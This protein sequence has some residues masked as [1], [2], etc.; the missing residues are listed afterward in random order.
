MRTRELKRMRAMVKRLNGRQRKILAA[1]L[2]AI[3]LVPAATE[4]A[5]RRVEGGAA[6]PHCAGSHIV[7]NGSSGGMQRYLCRTCR[8]TFNGLTGT[9]LARLRMKGK[10][11]GQAEALRD[12]LSL[13]QVEERLSIARTTAFRWRHRF[14]VLP[15][16]LRAELLTGVAE[17]DETYFL[18]SS[19]G[20][21]SGLDRKPRRRGG[22]ASRPGVS[23]E[24][25]P[26]L[27]ARDRAGGTADFILKSDD[28]DHIVEKLKPILPKD[29]ILCTEG[30][31]VMMATGRKLAV[32][33][34]AVNV[35]AGIRVDGPWHV[36]NVN[37]YHSRL[38]T[39]LRR[40]KGVATRYLDSYLGWFRAIDRSPAVISKPASF[41]AMAVGM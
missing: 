16:D 12:G 8:K 6:C 3:E 1:D 27:V 13:T 19:K 38:K 26:V 28:S 2:A 10:W 9:P 23:S 32:E 25:V 4:V 15:K 11:L 7:K 37:S 33:H 35:A 5:E 36:Q 41:L 31:S 40:F 21:R 18:R 17:A 30:N 22:A 20:Y 24:Q 39:W 34:H 29:A 14:L